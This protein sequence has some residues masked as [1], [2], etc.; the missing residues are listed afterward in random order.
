M[1]FTAA[2]SKTHLATLHPRMQKMIRDWRHLQNAAP[3]QWRSGK[4]S[5]VKPDKLLTVPPMA[6][7]FVELPGKKKGGLGREGVLRLICV[8][9]ALGSR[10]RGQ[11]LLSW[12]LGNLV[13]EATSIG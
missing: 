2:R 12:C 7:P 8:W 1:E 9:D 3:S 10:D 5:N 13:S 6:G 4:G 11:A